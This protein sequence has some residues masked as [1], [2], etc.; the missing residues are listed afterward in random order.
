MTNLADTIRADLFRYDGANGFGPFV[1][2]YCREP[3]F[4]FTVWLRLASWSAGKPAIRLFSL[5]A[6]WWRSRLEVRYGISIPHTTSIGPG[7][8]IGH[9]GGIVVS[10]HARIGRNCDLSNG[11]TIGQ[12][13]RGKRKGYPIIGDSVYIGPGSRILGNITV[14]SNVAIGANAVVI[15]DVPDNAVVAGVPAR[16]VS[17]KGSTG[18]VN[19]TLDESSAGNACRQ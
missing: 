5:F 2:T 13:N 19:W 1:K 15:D 10:L 3:G 12:M 7:L 8:Y 17:Y 14:G 18:Y 6:R 16:V 9:F 11:V 4:H